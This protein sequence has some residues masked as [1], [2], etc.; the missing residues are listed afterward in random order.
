MLRNP[1]VYKPICKTT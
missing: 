1:S